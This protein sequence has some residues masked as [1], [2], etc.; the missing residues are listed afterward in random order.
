N[1]EALSKDSS[2]IVIDV[3]DLFTK[4]VESISGIPSYLRRTY[5]IRRL[6]SD[7]SFVESVK[8]FPENIEVRQV[9]TYV[10]GN[11]PSAEYTQTLSVEVS[12]SIVLLPEEPM[13]KRYADYRVGYFSIRQIDYGSDEQK[14]AQKEYIR[15]WR[16]EPKD[17]EAYARGELVEPVK[18]IVYY[19]DPATPEKYRSYI[20]QG[21]LDWNEAFEEA[22][23][24][25]AVQAKL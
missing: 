2:G 25:N 24:K 21:I 20:I 7:R 18:P 5:Q 19:L 12:Q 9:M 6:D 3:T 22:G 8:S 15:R 1:I 16:L 23:F 4:D 14:A 11:P 17:P 10:A 13:R